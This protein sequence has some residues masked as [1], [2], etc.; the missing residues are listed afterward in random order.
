[1]NWINT[2][3][4]YG[5]LSITLH[6]LMFL[7]ITL[8]YASIELRELFDKGT[9][10]HNT[11]KVW[12]FTLG[13]SVLVLAVLRLGLVVLQKK[14]VIEPAPNSLQQRSAKVVHRFLYA[15]MIVMPIL[16][17]LILSGEGKTIPFY[18]GLLPALIPENNFLANVFE[19]VHEI[20]GEIG[21]WLIGLHA[22]AALFHHYFLRDNTLIRMLP[23]KKD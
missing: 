10:V 12:H 21:Y 7:L 22:F 1:M 5:V 8:T 4:S 14:P 23:S 6:W 20:I 9:E 2:P 13:L 3:R 15:F 11:F 17:W 16:G 18:N 19:E